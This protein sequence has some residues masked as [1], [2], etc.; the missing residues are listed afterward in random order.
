MTEATFRS[1]NASS[2]VLAKYNSGEDQIKLTEA[3]KYWFIC[4]ISGHCLGGMRFAINV[5]EANA[6]SNNSTSGPSPPPSPNKSCA[7][8]SGRSMV[9]ILLVFD[10]LFKIFW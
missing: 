10:L 9:Y 5:T 1:C 6:A 4:N 7:S 2:G 3:K 8:E